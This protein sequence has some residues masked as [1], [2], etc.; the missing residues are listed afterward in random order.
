MN[1]VHDI[2][3]GE[4][5]L[6]KFRDWNTIVKV[7]DELDKWGLSFEIARTQFKGSKDEMS[8]HFN[9]TISTGINQLV[10]FYD[11]LSKLHEE[12]SDDLTHPIDRVRK[13]TIQHLEEKRRITERELSLRNYKTAKWTLWATIGAIILALIA[14]FS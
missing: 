5:K 14:I 11:Y 9:S 13:L 3:D 1:S 2:I 8:D 7:I 4:E 12:I 6:N 10:A